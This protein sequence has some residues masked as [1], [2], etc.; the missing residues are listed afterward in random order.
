VRRRSGDVGGGDDSSTTTTTTTMT[1]TYAALTADNATASTAPAV[2][3][4]PHQWW[5]A[6]F[7]WTACHKSGSPADKIKSVRGRGAEATTSDTND[8][9]GQLQSVEVS[10]PNGDGLQETVWTFYTSQ[11]S[12]EAGLQTRN[13]IPDRH[14]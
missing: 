13:A 1:N 14:Q 3:S 2:N 6:N 7:D 8:P 5:I 11:E 4:A 9:S 10:A 12:C